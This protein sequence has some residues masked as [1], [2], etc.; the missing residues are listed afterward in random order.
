MDIRKLNSLPGIRLSLIVTGSVVI[1]AGLCCMFVPAWVAVP[2]EWLV[3]GTMFLTGSAAVLHLAA[4]AVAFLFGSATQEDDVSVLSQD[5]LT[6]TSASV[7]RRS[8]FWGV[9]ILQV[10]IGGIM[11]ISPESLRPYW[12]LLLMAAIVV[13]A[14]LILWL[15]LHF[16][17]FAT[18]VGLWANG[19]VSLVVFAI[20]MLNR[21]QVSVGHWI[22]GLLG[23]KL[24]MLGWALLEIGIRA[25][26]IDLR[27]AYIGEGRFHDTPSVGSIYAVYYGPAFHCGIS[28]GDGQIV[29]Y[30]SDGI[31]R[32][33]TWDEFLLG[34]RALEWNYPDVP[35]GEPTAICVFAR[36]L[37][38]KYNKYDALRFNCENLAIYC[39]SLGQTTHS[40]FS[41]AAVGVELVKRKPILGSLLQMLNRAASWFLYGAGG[42]FGKQIGFIMI[43][44]A[45]A[46]TDWV[47]ARPL[48]KTMDFQKPTEIYT[49]VFEDR[50]AN[51]DTK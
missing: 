28:V 3:G 41:Q 14:G 10:L 12:S 48:R 36:R 16:S 33:V 49:P 35:T 44:V 26:D 24:L 29:D 22:G 9:A 34:R 19:L 32:L 37:V 17:S 13:E 11:L 30:L 7:A 51:A 50:N 20:V 1:V 4:G 31:V 46:I 47:I 27:F 8:P 6:R 25:S 23:A 15:S 5:S 18:K 21:P 43:R 40:S 38:G 45:R 39:R 2:L 42:P